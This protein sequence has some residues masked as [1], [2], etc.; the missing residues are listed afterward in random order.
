MSQLASVDISVDGRKIKQFT[1]FSLR[2][3]VFEHHEFRLIIPVE[4]LDSVGIFHSS[5]A[6]IGAGIAVQIR[7]RWGADGEMKFFGVITQAE[8]ARND[9]YA[10]NIIL[11]GYSPTILMENGVHFKTW[12]EANI[13]KMANHVI[14]HFR[15]NLLKANISPVKADNIPYMAQYRETAWQFLCRLCAAYGEWLFYDGTELYIGPPRAPKKELEFGVNLTDFNIALQ[16]RPVHFEAR[17]LDY[18][19][20]DVYV[21]SPSQVDSKAGLNKMGKDLLEKSEKFYGA[22]PRQWASIF[23]KDKRQLDDLATMQAAIQSSNMVRFHGAGDSL[24]LHIGGFVNVKGSAVYSND[25]EALG[26]Y[27][28][29][30]IHHHCDGQENYSNSFTAIPASVKVPP[31]NSFEAP[32]CESQ[33]GVVVDNKDP[34]KMG[35]IRVRFHWMP[36]TD[37]TPWVRMATMHAGKGRGSYFLPEVGDE[38]MVGFEG[39]DP[40]HPFVIGTLYNGIDKAETFYNQDNDVKAIQTRSGN[41]I[42]MNDKEG[43]IFVEDKDGNSLKMDGEGNIKVLANKSI[44]LTCG[45]AKIEMRED[46]T[47][48]ITGKQITVNAQ[49]KATMVSKQASFTADGNG[50]EAAMA[51]MKAN[52]SGSTEA[53]VAGGAKTDITASGQVAVKGAMIMLN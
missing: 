4:V 49:E 51:G 15:S 48:N 53:K 34:E 29:I 31:V 45:E 27:Q 37:R 23:V 36:D 8:T 46:G 7:P 35:R 16:V 21:S 26:D 18:L 28:I 3:S 33:S 6:M 47:I 40:N 1:S 42:I 19:K 44:E 11:T 13:K 32:R 25:A 12:E 52:V 43:S 5:G 2:Q 24:G 17:A 14:G 50:G 30:A 22:K 20:K 39:G 9:N 10:G 41:K 38:V